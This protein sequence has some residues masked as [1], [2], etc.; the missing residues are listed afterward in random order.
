M[1]K[2]VLVV[3]NNGKTRLLRCYDDAF[4]TSK[5]NFVKA[6]FGT[7]AKTKESYCNV[8]EDI[9]FLAPGLKCVFRQYATLYFVFVIDEGESEL[10]V[11]DLI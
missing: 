2:A 5:E 7:L 3:N 8:L 1:I 11:L 10:A 6:L 9:P 4:A